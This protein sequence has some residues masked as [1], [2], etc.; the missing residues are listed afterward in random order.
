MV[1]EPR[2]VNDRKP[3]HRGPSAARLGQGRNLMT[4]NPAVDHGHPEPGLTHV[5]KPVRYVLEPGHVPRSIGVCRPLYVP[6][7]DLLQ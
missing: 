1:R 4:I 5:G 6:E 3:Y 2:T 7:L